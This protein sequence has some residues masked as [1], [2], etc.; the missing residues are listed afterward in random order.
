MLP[1][2][3]QRDDRAAQGHADEA[4]RARLN[5]RAREREAQP[6]EVGIEARQRWRVR[7]RATIPADGPESTVGV[8]LGGIVVDR[9]RGLGEYGE[10]AMNDERG[11][12]LRSRSRVVEGDEAVPRREVRG[13]MD[14]DRVWRTIGPKASTANVASRTCL[15]RGMLQQE[16]RLPRRDGV[17]VSRVRIGGAGEVRAAGDEA[18]ADLDFKAVVQ[19]QSV[20]FDVRRGVLDV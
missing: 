18:L 1:V 7:D 16:M 11:D 6:G 8:E 4:R 2:G 9:S 3:L 13:R 20:E 19:S 17:P 14:D 15:E 12:S 10:A 5:A